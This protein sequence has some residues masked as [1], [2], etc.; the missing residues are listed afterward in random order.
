MR[1]TRDSALPK[2]LCVAKENR[3]MISGGVINVVVGSR[4]KSFFI[5]EDL[6]RRSSALFRKALE[7]P[8]VEAT[9]RTVHLPNDRSASFAI[10]AHWLYFGNLPIVD[11]QPDKSSTEWA[12]L[13][14]A[15]VLGDKLLC[16]GLQNATL[17]AI[18][19]KLHGKSSGIEF[20]PGKAVVNRIYEHT[21]P[22]DSLRRFLA[23]LYIAHGCREWLT[24]WAGDEEIPQAFATDILKGLL[25]SREEQAPSRCHLDSSARLIMASAE[26]PANSPDKRARE[27]SQASEPY[28]P[29]KFCLAR[30]EKETVYGSVV[31]VV[32]G[33]ASEGKPSS[34]II[35][36]DLLRLSSK[37]FDKALSGPWRES[38]ERTIEL[39]G[40]DPDVFA[41]YV[42]WL[43]SG[44]T[45]TANPSRTSSTST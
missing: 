2:R 20:Y 23:E 13:I 22:G 26:H 3:E 41:M 29:K 24:N 17:D 33:S 1:K 35:H 32:V 43:Y 6:L 27:S 36:E 44:T 8:W 19:M 37:L 12:E 28:N 18:S 10:Y 39:P 34:A 7:G 15:Y 9:Q 14:D 31:I 4:Q 30:R 11:S 5:H 42:H 38:N 40:D 16:S 45:I 21:I 25:P